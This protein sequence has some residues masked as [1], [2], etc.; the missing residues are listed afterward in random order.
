VAADSLLISA[1]DL[2]LLL[3]RSL[4]AGPGLALL[5]VRWRLGGPPGIDAYQAGH[6]RGA[7]FVDLDADLAG[8]PG[9]GGRHPLPSTADFQAAMRRAGVRDGVPVVV[10]DDAD[11]TAAARAWW[12]LRYFGHG[13]PEHGRPSHGRVRVLDGGLQTWRA[14]GLPVSTAGET[15]APGDFTA[16]PGHLPVLDAAGAA[17]VARAGILLDARAP[18]RYRGETEPVDRVA[19]HIPGAVSAPTAGNVT[20]DGVFR[21]IAELRARFADLGIEAAAGDRSA[22][23]A[24]GDGGRTGRAGEEAGAVAMADIGQAVG[25]Y[26][27]SGVTA[28]HEVLALEL[29]GIPAALYVGSWSA[30]ISDPDRPVA[31]GPQPGSER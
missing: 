30:W 28:A 26:C 17:E 4:A 23:D 15:A 18:A 13:R 11:S 22:G 7:F 24:A 19:G 3:S 14:A 8:P 6:V 5:D 16:E 1:A 20:S 12:L 27:G 2:S 10:Y 25:A 21:P 31:T 9:A 29:A